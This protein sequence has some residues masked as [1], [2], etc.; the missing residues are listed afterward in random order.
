[1]GEANA[2]ARREAPQYAVDRSGALRN[3]GRIT[4]HRDREAIVR[5]CR[6]S[7]RFR[8]RCVPAHCRTAHVR[9]VREMKHHAPRSCA[10]GRVAAHS[11]TTNASTTGTNAINSRIATTNQAKS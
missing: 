9:T 3:D 2:I 1:M 6:C 5:E 7:D 8:L 11:V 10:L 4:V